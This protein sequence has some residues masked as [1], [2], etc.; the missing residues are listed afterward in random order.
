VRFEVAEEHRTFA[1]SVRSAVGDWKAPLE[2]ELGVWQDDRDS[3]LDVR[4]EDVGWSALWADGELLG[5]AVAGAFELG[6]AVAPICVVDE[7][8]LGA[9]LW[10]NG[11]ARH[12]LAAEAL[13]IPL[14]RGGLA[15]G[16]PGS[17]SVPEASLDGSGT[18]RVEIA[19][20]EELDPRSAAARWQAWSAA[21]LAYLA[22]LGA[23][24]L[25]LAVE[26]ARAREQFGAPL[27]ALPAV[28]SRLADAALAVDATTLLAWSHGNGPAPWTP[29][30]LW[31]GSACC[32]VT[33]GVIQVHGA[34]G[35]ALESGLHRFHRRA[36]AVHT[37]TT[38]ACAAAR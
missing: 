26:H 32:D 20:A 37:W 7:A 3:A 25:E 30:L 4:L 16:Q 9:T 21:T 1:D 17:E 36:R 6:R 2:P 18:A 23:R 33:A 8:T 12:A 29:A 31:A 13:A 35:F 34:I 10:V 14:A 38:G 22:G 15:L 11:R 27:A 19:G 5:A 24:G 28:Q